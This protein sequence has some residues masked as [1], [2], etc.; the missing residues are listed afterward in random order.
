MV[1]FMRNLLKKHPI[2][3]YLIIAYGI[4][5][6]GWIPSLI[7][8]SK[9]GYLLPTLDGFVNFIQAG[10]TDT[11]HIFI[12][13][14]FQFAIYGPLIGALI[15]IGLVR[16]KP[17]IAELWG[18]IT[19]LRIGGR[20]Y[21]RAL[22]LAFVLAFVPLLLATTT[23]LVNFNG[24]GLLALLPFVPLLLIW[25]ILTSGLEEPGWRG[26]LLP[27][28]QARFGGEKY[29]WLLGLAWAGWHYPFTIYHTLASIVDMPVP[30]MVISVIFALAGNT[31][32]IIGMTYLY[33]W[34]NNN[35]KSVFLA[36]LFHTITNVANTVAFSAMGEFN[37]LVTIAVGLMPWAVIIVMKKVLG[38]D[39][40]PGN[41][42]TS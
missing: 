15:V 36:I 41:I 8:S 7:F 21:L 13:L 11:N 12:V 32:S 22:L 14:S 20:W 27:E 1:I 38:K 4:T 16:G 28:L 34:L 29:I 23:R 5:W 30:T 24:S 31:M 9:Q 18:R 42:V 19:K 3:F 26:F 35:T 39:K 10:F 40:F 33:V 2:F 25:Q 6:L 17:G 37:P